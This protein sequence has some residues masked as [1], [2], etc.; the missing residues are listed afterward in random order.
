MSQAFSLYSELTVRQ[1][2][3][4]HAR[5]FQRARRDDRR[6]GRGDGRSA[7]TSLDVIDALPDTLPLGQRQRLSLAVAM[8]HEPELL[9]LDEPTS[10]VDPVARDA[11]WR[12]MIDLSRRDQVTIFISTHFMNEAERCDRISLMH[13]GRV[14][15]SDTP[16]ALIASSAARRRW[17]RPSS[18]IWRRR[19]PGR[20]EAGARAREP[21]PAVAAPELTT[22][23]PAARRAAVFDLRRMFSYTRREALELRRDP[24]RA[25]LALLGTRHPDVHHRLRHQ[26]GRGG[27]DLRGA[28][29]RPDHD[30]P[31]LRA[32]PLRLA[33]LHRAARRS[34]TT[35]IS[36]GA[37]APASS[38]WR[39]R[40]PPASPATRPRPSGG[41]RRLDRR[42]HADSAPRPC[43]LRAG[44]ARAVA[45]RR[46]ARLGAGAAGLVT[47]ETRFRYNPD[48]K[49]LVAMVPGGDPAAADADPGDAD[50]A[51]RGAREGARARSST[52][53]SRRSRGCE[54]L[55][56]KQLA[57]RRAGDAQLPAADGCS[58]SPCS[59]CRS[60]A[61]SRP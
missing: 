14:L 21:A 18:P 19:R 24:I 2:L 50:G 31:R 51:R 20:P 34:P 40:F 28:R 5:L 3:E 48:V 11:F 26:H 13:A 57:L 56:G 17:R 6:P 38:A 27:P 7:S 44:H 47:I 37:C 43:G 42:R 60:R 54:F 36:T 39:S 9:I 1:N 4:L 25:T 46:H 22:D 59:A 15:V 16:A 23:R 35:P 33:L 10:G 55:L 49:S 52:S 29:P 61:A 12:I 30:Q 58:R 41:D 32:Q 45:G 8:I 53:T